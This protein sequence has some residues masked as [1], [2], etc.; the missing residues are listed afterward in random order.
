MVKPRIEPDRFEQHGHHIDEWWPGLLHSTWSYF[1][2]R[3]KVRRERRY[4][5]RDHKGIKAVS[6]EARFKF[7]NRTS[8]G[9]KVQRLA[10]RSNH[11]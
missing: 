10:P 6:Y 3:V 1:N 4:N 8:A 11:W 9:L 5:H 2:G 7:G